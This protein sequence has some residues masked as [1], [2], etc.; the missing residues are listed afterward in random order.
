MEITRNN[1][2]HHHE[3]SCINTALPNQIKPTSPRSPEWLAQDD[4][5]DLY[6]YPIDTNA[7][8]QHWLKRVYHPQHK[9]ISN[10]RPRYSTLLLPL[11]S[12]TTLKPP[13]ARSTRSP[14]PI[15]ITTECLNSTRTMSAPHSTY[16]SPKSY[17]GQCHPSLVDSRGDMERKVSFQ[18]PRT[19]DAYHQK[20]A[21]LSPGGLDMR[22]EVIS[23]SIVPHLV[24]RNPD[25]EIANLS[26]TQHEQP[27]L[28]RI[29]EYHNSMGHASTHMSSVAC[30]TSMI[31]SRCSSA[32]K[33]RVCISPSTFSQTERSIHDFER[34]P[35]NPSLMMLKG[36]P[37]EFP[38]DKGSRASSSRSSGRYTHIV[39]TLGE[40]YGSPIHTHCTISNT[41]I[42]TPRTISKAGPDVYTKKLLDDTYSCQNK[43]SSYIPSCLVKMQT[44]RTHLDRFRIEQIA[45]RRLRH[46]IENK[47]AD[48]S[49]LEVIHLLE[50]SSIPESLIQ[51]FFGP[52]FR[53][54][55][56]LRVLLLQSIDST[57]RQRL[58][59][60]EYHIAI[61][62][63]TA[64]EE[65][66]ASHQRKGLAY[67]M[68]TP[69]GLISTLSPSDGVSV[70][71]TQGSAPSSFSLQRSNPCQMLQ[72]PIE[73][74]AV[75]AQV[76]TVLASE[77]T[78]K[79]ARDS[80][81]QH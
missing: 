11:S 45:L 22:L 64:T 14:S 72:T 44:A 30:T 65:S 34:V 26:S 79:R 80:R 47:Q 5:L 9:L 12:P 10:P 21:D 15:L 48:S 63:A 24:Q 60:H 67:S 23:H 56:S 71:S 32:S 66:T 76:D 31:S 38:Q 69:S 51:K 70:C 78:D 62:E 54:L 68:K 17:R 28:Q 40:T 16:R 42:A 59:T 8:Y 1:S 20:S 73:V 41:A 81:R 35:H 2:S 13:V 77:T 58:H 3:L 57:H 49:H 39:P 61:D 75:L 37:E 7:V 52:S 46:V 53:T 25:T 55:H 4:T 19:A 36:S 50:Q 29:P 33:S 27:N 74:L 6:R 43:P 18:I